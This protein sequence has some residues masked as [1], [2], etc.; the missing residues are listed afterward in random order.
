[1]GEG[2]D[3]GRLES[4]LK[5]ALL[6]GAAGWRD[7]DAVYTSSELAAVALLVV[8]V[9]SVMTVLLVSA[10]LPAHDAAIG[11]SARWLVAA[12]GGVTLVG[13][14][15][16]SFAWPLGWR[17]RASGPARA[18]AAVRVGAGML[19]VGCWTALL[20][21]T[22]PAPI[23]T[24]GGV[25]GCEYTMTAWALGL[26]TGGR[27]WLRSFEGSS[28]HVGIWLV[29]LGAALTNRVRALDLLMVPLTFQVI[30]LAAGITCYGLERLRR[31]I[32]YRTKKAA[33]SAATRAHY[34]LAHWL[35]DDIT[36]SLRFVRLG[37]RTGH[38]THA[39]AATELDQLDHRLRLRQLE[40]MLESGS[41]QLAEVL[42]PYVR[43]AQSKG[44]EVVEVP[45][46]DAASATLDGTTGRLVQR[47]LSVIVPNA[48]TAGARQLAF[49]I[50][51]I[52]RQHLA[53]EVEDD[54]GG[55]EL[56]A[57][58]A[59]RGL[60]GL[61]RDLGPGKVTCARTDKGSRLQVIIDRGEGGR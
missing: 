15:W 42:Q 3:A 30:A 10:G 7:R 13:A 24:L 44:V 55:F 5:T 4:D 8:C 31:A 53:I 14:V 60:D 41:T 61:R 59:G 47:T 16:P 6:T 56:A 11:G 37:V 58:P 45:R 54:A 34:R 32:D 50:E 36:T 51:P 35:H 46:F 27:S 52:D 1:V 25:V 23:W 28:L 40:E 17:P 21:R 2:A 9:A 26:R 22:S 39:E 33:R 49:R 19:V 20:G 43:L 48:I 29:S 18:F 57:V 12:L 38:M